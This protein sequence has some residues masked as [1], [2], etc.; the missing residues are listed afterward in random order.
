[1]DAEALNARLSRLEQKVASGLVAAPQK[2]EPGPQAFEAP[3]WD[4]NDCPPWDDGDAPP[5]P[6]EPP[7]QPEQREP[8]G[9]WAK[10]VDQLRTTL[11]PPA[12]AMFVMNENAPVKGSLSGDVLTLVCRDEFTKKII[13]TPNVLQTAAECAAAQLGRSVRVQVSLPGETKK[14][15]EGFARLIQFG[16]QHP[17]LVDFK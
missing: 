2:Q 7:M 11:K 17:D 8:I 10:L 13:N 3:P 5:L 1:M 12:M 4:D 15:N 16:Q 6:D 14:N 9:F